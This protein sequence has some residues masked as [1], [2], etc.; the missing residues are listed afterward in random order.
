LGNIKFLHPPKNSISYGNAEVSFIPRQYSGTT[1]MN[2]NIENN[3]TVISCN[4]RKSQR[5]EKVI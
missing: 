4:A 2:L 1:D 5:T 3:I